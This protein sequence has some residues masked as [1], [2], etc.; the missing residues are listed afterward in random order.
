MA[1]FDDDNEDFREDDEAEGALTPEQE[2]ALEAA[3]DHQL[4]HIP[5]SLFDALRPVLLLAGLANFMLVGHGEDP[6]PQ[7][8]KQ[9]LGFDAETV[10]AVNGVSDT[11]GLV[12]LMLTR[13]VQLLDFVLVGRLVFESSLQPAVGNYVR[14][15]SPETEKPLGWPEEFMDVQSASLLETLG[16]FLGATNEGAQEELRLRR[17]QTESIFARLDDTLRAF[18]PAGL[19]PEERR[20]AELDADDEAED[21]EDAAVQV[22]FSPIQRT[23]L[24]LALRLPHLLAGLGETPFARALANV[25]RFRKKALTRLADR[26]LAAEDDVPFTLA[27]SEMLRLYQAA[28]VCALSSVAAVSAVGS[29]ED[30]LVQGAASPAEAPAVTAEDA[31]H[32]REVMTTMMAGFV[33]VVETNHPDDEDVAA[34]RAEIGQLAELLVE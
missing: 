34:A 31:R 13:P 16:Q 30:F 17:L 11:R 10:R 32:T 28:H 23:T 21:A 3:L 8:L 7:A 27:W 29:L 18:Y 26:L 22:S 2:A 24:A 14:S 6:V 19:S 9:L 4:E 25:P 1:E 12:R 15:Q 5:E 33:E 20:G